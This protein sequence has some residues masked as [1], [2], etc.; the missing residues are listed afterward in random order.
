VDCL[1][2]AVEPL[3]ERRVRAADLVAIHLPMHTATRLAGPVAQ[4]VRQLNPRARLCFYGLYA[5]MNAA[6]LRSLGADHVLGGE[7]ESGLAALVERWPGSRPPTDD[8]EPVLSLERLDF[9]VPERDR[10]PALSRYAHLHDATGAVRVVGYTEASRG[11]KHACRHCPVV[12]VYRR[13]FRIVQ[14]EVVL[15]DIRRQV[16]GGAQHITFGDPDFLNGPRHALALV[17]RLHREHP[18]LTYDVTVKI[19]HLLRHRQHLEILRRTG[20][21]FVT[22]AVE[23]IDDRVLERLDKGHTRADFI[24][25]LE[26]CR[27]A[28]LVLNPTFVAFTPW[29]TARGYGELLELLDRLELVDQVAPVQLAIRLLIP[30]G[31]LLLELPEVRDLVGPFDPAALVHPWRHPDPVVDALQQEVDRLVRSGSARRES[32]GEIFARVWD[33]ARRAAGEPALP[34]RSIGRDRAPVPYLTE[35][36]YC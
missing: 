5:T 13:R 8:F 22:S 2:L 16:A 9:L 10:L 26:A 6:H 12:P 23:S 17:Q 36:W 30:A 4:R 15:E 20:C 29:I 35:P 32:R 14:P 28:G 3:D 27:R 24:A 33:E 34:P 1:D 18:R 21:L 25:A 31:S 19:E 7:F 11:C